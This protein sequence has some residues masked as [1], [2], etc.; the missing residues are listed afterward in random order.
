MWDYEKVDDNSQTVNVC[1][2]SCV[3]ELMLID[4]GSRTFSEQ[5]L[6]A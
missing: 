2:T 4:V 1:A 5:T 6:L 3:N